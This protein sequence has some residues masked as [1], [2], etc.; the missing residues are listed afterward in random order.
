MSVLPNKPGARQARSASDEGTEIHRW[1][2]GLVLLK[3][4]AAM[5]RKNHRD[6]DKR[7]SATSRQA[8]S[9]SDEGMATRRWRSGLVGLSACQL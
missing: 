4:V 8:R 9:A 3:R 5:T 2:S 1:R 7:R 6:F